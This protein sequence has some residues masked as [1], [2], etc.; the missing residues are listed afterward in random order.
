[1]STGK[2]ALGLLAGLAA[3]DGSLAGQG[4]ERL[5][6]RWRKVGAYESAM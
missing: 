2:L 4:Y 6:S 5:V 3:G 1:M